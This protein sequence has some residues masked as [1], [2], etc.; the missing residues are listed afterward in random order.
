MA[1]VD[2][3]IISPVQANSGARSESLA[4]Q[5]SKGWDRLQFRIATQDDLKSVIENEPINAGA[6]N[7]PTYTALTLYN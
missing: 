6:A 2:Q 3:V 7:T 1:R 5:W 4:A